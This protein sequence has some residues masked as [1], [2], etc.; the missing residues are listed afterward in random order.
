MTGNPNLRAKVGPVYSYTENP[1]LSITDIMETQLD[2]T[3]RPL[4][5]RATHI[6]GGNTIVALDN[7]AYDHVGAGS[8][9]MPPLPPRKLLCIRR[10]VVQEQTLGGHTW[11]LFLNQYDALGQLEAK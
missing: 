9:A 8:A 4:R 3:G 11:T 10:S 5:T 2:F 6:R 7:F 1:Y